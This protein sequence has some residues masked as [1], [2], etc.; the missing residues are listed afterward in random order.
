[1]GYNCWRTCS[2][3]R[4]WLS[5]SN[6]RNKRRNRY[7]INKNDLEFIGGTISENISGD[8]INR[9]FNEFYVVHKNIDIKDIVLQ[10]EEVQDIKWFDKEDIVKKINNNYETLTDKVGCWNYLLKYFEINN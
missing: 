6:Q 5:N 4:I 1:M 10:E 7:Y 2:D 9:H 8:I 3:W